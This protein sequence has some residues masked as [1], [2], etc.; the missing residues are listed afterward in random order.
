LNEKLSEIGK[1]C[2]Q[3][4]KKVGLGPFFAICMKDDQGKSQ[5][6]HEER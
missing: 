1:I 2:V 6:N 5:L 4:A 3:T